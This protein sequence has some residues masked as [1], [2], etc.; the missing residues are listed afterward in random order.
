MS[1][2]ETPVVAAIRYTLPQPP[3]LRSAANYMATATVGIDL[4]TTFSAIAYVNEHG[5][6][7]VL[8]NAEGDRITPVGH[9]V[10]GRRRHR[11]Q[12][13]QA[14]RGGLPRAGGRVRQ[15]PHGRR[16]LPVQVQ[17]PGATPRGAVAASSSPSSSTTPS[18][19]SGTGGAGGHHR[20]RLL[21][22]QAARATMRAGRAGGLRSSSCSTSPRPPRSPTG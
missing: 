12:L 3:S 11:R 5:V 22:R 2:R 7:E 15:A 14:G 6:P 20:A 10:R 13:R 4:G 8:P 18:C 16:H 1:T 19:A 21:Q 17:G 9:P